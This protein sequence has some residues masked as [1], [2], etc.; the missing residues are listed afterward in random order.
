[1]LSML[2]EAVNRALKDGYAACGRR[3]TWDG[4]LGI[5]RTS[6]NCWSMNMGW[7]IFR[8][9]PEL[10]AAPQLLARKVPSVAATEL[11]Q[12]LDG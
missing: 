11:Q 7:G 10:Y 4:S 2:E 9:V 12:M 5:R 1:M 6:R 8:R 3:V